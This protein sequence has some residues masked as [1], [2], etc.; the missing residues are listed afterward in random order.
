MPFRLLVYITELLKREFESTDENER[1]RK[2][3]RLPCVV[4]IVLYNGKDNWT[5]VRTLKEYFQGYEIF[6][7][8][9]LDF[10][11]LLFDLN[12]ASLSST[13]ELVNIIL[14][15]D[16]KLTPE[17]RKNALQMAA[18]ASLKMSAADKAELLAW[19]RE[20]QLSGV[21][22]SVKDKLLSEF[23]RGE[24]ANMMYG[25]DFEYE[26]KRLEGRAEGEARGI[27]ITGGRL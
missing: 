7:E 16:K 3:F 24:V 13:L 8:Y 11:Y 19:I 22:E 20:I 25:I 15:L 2:D 26:E 5:V 23:E 9:A 6:G 12:R 27:V 1:A 10:T 14:H 4:P 21:E 18:E 17:E